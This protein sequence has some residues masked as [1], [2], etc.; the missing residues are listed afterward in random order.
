MY[1]YFVTGIGLLGG[2]Y[3]QADFFLYFIVVCSGYVIQS[4]RKILRKFNLH[5]MCETDD[6]EIHRWERRE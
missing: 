1:Y 4:P 5:I 6:H 3:E 2:V